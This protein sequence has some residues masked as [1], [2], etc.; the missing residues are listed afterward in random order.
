MNRS[1]GTWLSALAICVMTLPVSAMEPSAKRTVTDISLTA[2][3]DLLG[4]I[5]DDAG[6]PLANAPIQVLHKTTVV[7]KAKT[8]A[9]GRYSVQGLRSGLHIVQTVNQSQACRFW[10]AGSAPPSAKRGLVMASSNTVLRGQYCDDGCGQGCGEGCG[11]SCGG[12]GCGCGLFG[13]GGG[14]MGV[15]LPIGAFAAVTAVTLAATTGND[16]SAP[17]VSEPASP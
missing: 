7:A 9:A 1:F 16:D 11:E 5:V 12:G 10:N 15:L 17:V 13:G 8:D 4:A 6:R 2:S 3:G 14:G